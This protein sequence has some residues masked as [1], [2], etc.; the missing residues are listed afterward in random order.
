MDKKTQALVEQYAKS[1]VE[2]AFEQDAV[3]T[4]QEEVSQIL[5]VFA[6][7]DLQTFL[8]RENVTLE[9]KKGSL[10]LFQES[11]SAYMNNFLEV[12]LLND[13]AD[14]LYDILSL[15]QVLFDQEANTY[16][17]SVTSASPL[18]E[19]QKARLLTIVSKKFDI[20]TRRLVEEIDENLI[21][22]FVIKANNKVVDT[23]IR[24]QLQTFKS[25]LK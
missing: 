13:R 7:T 19:S 6:D 3:S 25:N 20:K 24:H 4:I 15:V 8:S 23:S 9:A 18:S 10:S 11:C 17:V 12:I 2:V 1:L 22:G 21:G 16:D 14:I 5:A